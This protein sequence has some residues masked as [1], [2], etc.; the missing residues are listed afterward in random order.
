MKFRCAIAGCG[1]IGSEFD[2]D[3]LM[4]KS[5]GIC[6]HAG[7]YMDNPNTELVAASDIKPEQ[8]EKF[9]K[10]WGVT[11]LYTDYREMLEKEKIDILSICTPPNTHPPIL[12][13]AIKHEVR[14]IFCE[15]PL[16]DFAD[17]AERMV[18]L[19]KNSNVILVVNH[20][21]RWDTLYQNVRDYIA[22]G[23]LGDIKHVSAYFTGGRVDNGTHMMDT[24]RMLCG[25]LDNLDVKV[26][27]LDVPYTFFEIDIYGTK[28][29]LR[30]ANNGFA[31][32]AWEVAES[33]KYSRHKEL[34]PEIN[35][36]TD[37]AGKSMMKNAIQN[38]VDCLTLDTTPFCTG[39]DGVKALEL[40]EEYL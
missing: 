24:L 19:A 2:D 6:S 26:N 38:I 11:N 27:H 7:G 4:R 13:C 29:R 37:P 18:W 5:Y 34:Y 21:R 40:V 16:A 10:K 22:D 33:D 14:A 12:E 39:D 23:N 28:R 20:S 31:T 30:V 3:P 1:R 36:C 8:L 17:R 9:K 25:E 32:H 35:F 15:K